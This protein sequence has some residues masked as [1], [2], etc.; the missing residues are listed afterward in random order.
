MDNKGSRKNKIPGT[1]RKRA[2]IVFALI[3]VCCLCF[4]AVKYREAGNR[5]SDD[6]GKQQNTAVEAGPESS[7]GGIADTASPDAEHLPEYDGRHYVTV[8][9]SV[10]EFPDEVIE[11]ASLIKDGERVA[12]YHAMDER[13]EAAF[14]LKM[15]TRNKG[16]SAFTILRGIKTGLFI[17]RKIRPRCLSDIRNTSSGFWDMCLFGSSRPAIPRSM[18]IRQRLTATLIR[19]GCVPHMHHPRERNRPCTV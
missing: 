14:V 3:L 8:N 11:K 9:G 15:S 7:E 17:F 19:R 2:F 10:P 16:F 1:G 18:Y 4:A 12:L 6:T 5:A 13:D